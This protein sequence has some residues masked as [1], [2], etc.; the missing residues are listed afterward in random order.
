LTWLLLHIMPFFTRVNSR[1]LRDFVN[2][3][4]WMVSWNLWDLDR[5]ILN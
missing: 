2:S 5:R 3:R 1:D 4:F